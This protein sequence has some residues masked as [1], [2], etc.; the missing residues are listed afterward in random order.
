ML[1]LE[2]RECVGG[3]RLEFEGLSEA[4][5]YNVG[6]VAYQRDPHPIYG[7][8]IS[9]EQALENAERM[10]LAWNSFEGIPTNMM[11]HMPGP[12]AELAC[13]HADGV[14]R[15]A[16]LTKALEDLRATQLGAREFTA[17]EVCDIQQ[18]ADLLIAEANAVD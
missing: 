11:R 2:V 10:V 12:V 3:Y 6:F 5:G 18:R 15:I 13:L 17:A 1:K 16:V 8:G 9:Q 14:K 7:G 4:R